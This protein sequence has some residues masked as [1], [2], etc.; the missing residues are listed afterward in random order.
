M[1]NKAWFGHRW[2]SPPI[3]PDV[4]C[5]WGNCIGEYG[6]DQR[7][8]GE[9]SWSLHSWIQEGYLQS[10]L[11]VISSAHCRQ[12]GAGM[13][14]CRLGQAWLLRE[15]DLD[16]FCLVFLGCRSQKECQESACRIKPLP[17]VLTTRE[18]KGWRGA[19]DTTW[20]SQVPHD[21]ESLSPSLQV[22]KLNSER[23]SHAVVNF[24]CETPDCLQR[25]EARENKIS[26]RVSWRMSSHRACGDERNQPEDELS[27]KKVT[28]LA[29]YKGNLHYT[30]VCRETKDSL[31]C[32][33]GRKN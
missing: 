23:L 7:D 24:M 28:S 22:K 3:L 6:L 5:L 19:L 26:R 16:P 25:T 32:D 21:G 9:L 30:E 8:T 11:K 15:T 14:W 1:G 20:S 29:S 17:R 33:W 2:P 31:L 13:W 18:Q 4:D 10:S 12:R 27:R